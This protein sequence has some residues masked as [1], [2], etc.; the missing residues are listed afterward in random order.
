[1]PINDRYA[2][3]HIPK[4]GGS[5]VAVLMGCNTCE[6]RPHE[7]TG[8]GNGIELTHLT[9]SEM[10]ERIGWDSRLWFAVLRNPWDRMVSE[11]AYCVG[12][13]AFPYLS[14]ETPTFPEFIRFATSPDRPYLIDDEHGGKHLRRQVDFVFDT[15][16]K[17][18]VDRIYLFRHIE[19]VGPELFDTPTPHVNASQHNPWWEWYDDGTARAVGEFFR[20]DARV[21]Y[22]LTPKQAKSRE[23]ARCS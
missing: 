19:R 2:F 20:D 10:Q 16:G 21:T 5:S 9:A 11:Y 12:M 13:G 14:G 7:L 4:T 6:Y 1:M 22:A 23:V 17:I 8:S 15:R 3:V 18:Q